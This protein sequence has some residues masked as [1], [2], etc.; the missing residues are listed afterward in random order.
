MSET[1]VIILIFVLSI[2]NES[3]DF[4]IKK[5]KLDICCKIRQKLK[6]NFD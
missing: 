1:T 4:K 3:L 2:M 6:T 5:T